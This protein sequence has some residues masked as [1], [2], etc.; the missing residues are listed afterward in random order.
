M[1]F[2]WLRLRPARS[3]WLRPIRAQAFPSGS[4]LRLHGHALDAP[5]VRPGRFVQCSRAQGC[6]MPHQN[7]SSHAPMFYDGTTKGGTNA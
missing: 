7:G 3:G 6:V 2:G 4:C 5:D 1:F